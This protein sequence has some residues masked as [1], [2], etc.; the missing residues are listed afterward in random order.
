MF[1]ELGIRG[2]ISNVVKR[3]IRANHV[4]V[5]GFDMNKPEEFLLYLD[6]NNLVRSTFC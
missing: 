6:A 2:G 4:Q 1:T 5:P 3:F